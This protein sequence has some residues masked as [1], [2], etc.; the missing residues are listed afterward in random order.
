MQTPLPHPDCTRVR[1]EASARLDGELSELEAVHLDNHLGRCPECSEYVRSLGVL[2]RR[3]RGAELEQPALPVLVA[4]GR[5]PVLR[6][7]AAVAA[8]TIAAAAGSSFAA[9]HFVGSRAGGS[10]VTVATTVSSVSK[11]RTEVLGMLRRI[12]PGRM[13]VNRVIPV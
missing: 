1:E 9:G 5:R 6:L 8:V 12:R 4:R 11:H 2:T 10:P 13:A 7:N 3:L